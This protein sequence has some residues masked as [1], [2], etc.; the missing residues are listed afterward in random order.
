MHMAIGAVVNAFWD[1][2]AKR[3]GMPLWRLLSRMSPS[4]LV[5]LVDFRYLSDALTRDEALDLLHSSAKPA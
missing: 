1:L 5:D 4:E 2:R 3:E